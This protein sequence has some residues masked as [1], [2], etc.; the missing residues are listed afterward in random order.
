MAKIIGVRFRNNGKIYYFDSGRSY[1]KEGSGVIVETSQGVEYADVVQETRE[2]SDSE[3]V[4]PLKGILRIAT[5]KD[6]QQA[7]L[8]R[9][10]EKEALE[11]ATAKIMEHQLDMKLVRVEYTFDGAKIVFYFTSEG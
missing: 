9:E 4:A 11:L 5:A 7:Q 6:I 8:N 2:A 10:K 1:I 3:I